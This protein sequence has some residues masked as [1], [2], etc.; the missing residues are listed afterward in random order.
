M[1][2][3]S[4]PTTV[5]DNDATFPHYYYAIS[6]YMSHQIWKTTTRSFLK[7]GGSA[8]IPFQKKSFLDFFDAIVT[9]IFSNLGYESL[10]KKY[11]FYHQN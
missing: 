10:S 3:S 11:H 2:T 6:W 4:P 7:L 8:A 9:D 1:T 5:E